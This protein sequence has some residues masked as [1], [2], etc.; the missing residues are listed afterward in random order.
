MER[1]LEAESTLYS[2]GYI[3]ACTAEIFNIKWLSYAAIAAAAAAATVMIVIISLY[4]KLPENAPE[5]KQFKKKIIYKSV[6][7]SLLIALCIL[8]YLSLC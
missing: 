3:F 6:F 7:L 5:R 4:C 2:L 8:T 1:K